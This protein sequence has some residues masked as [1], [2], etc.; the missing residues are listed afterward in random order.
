MPEQQFT[1]GEGVRY[2]MERHGD[3][4]ASHEVFLDPNMSQTFGE[5]FV[6][7]YNAADGEVRVIVPK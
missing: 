4:P 5:K 1:I 7:L 2:E 6:Y 3:K